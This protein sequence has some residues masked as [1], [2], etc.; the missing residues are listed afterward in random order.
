MVNM[1]FNNDRLRTFKFEL[2]YK[3]NNNFGGDL[4]RL[5]LAFN[6][7]IRDRMILQRGAHVVNPRITTTYE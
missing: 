4:P 1:N 2:N 6:N 3:N 5:F 7:T